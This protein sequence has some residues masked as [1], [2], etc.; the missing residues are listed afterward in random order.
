[1]TEGS[2]GVDL[3]VHLPRLVGGS[4]RVDSLLAEAVRSRVNPG[5]GVRVAEV[6]AR[7]LRDGSRTAARRLVEVLVG[8]LHARTVVVVGAPD[9]FLVRVH[10]AAVEQGCVDQ[11][12]ARRLGAGEALLIA[13][14]LDSVSP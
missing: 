5:S 9:S 11:V 10:A 2:P 12:F 7:E 1:M 6:L 8:D 13:D 4:A 3:A 14:Y